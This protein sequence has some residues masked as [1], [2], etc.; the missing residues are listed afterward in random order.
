MQ[1]GHLITVRLIF[2]RSSPVG[3]TLPGFSF[4][5]SSNLTSYFL[6]FLITFLVTT[7]KSSPF[8]LCII[9]LQFLCVRAIIHAALGLFLKISKQNFVLVIPSY[10][11]NDV[12]F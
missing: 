4:Q 3:I 8:Q 10:P 6:A 7:K 1:A 11:K 2:S 9:S 12:N 5:I